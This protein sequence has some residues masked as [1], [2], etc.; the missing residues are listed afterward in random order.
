MSPL[1]RSPRFQQLVRETVAASSMRGLKVLEASVVSVLEHVV[2]DRAQRLDLPA[3]TVLEHIRVEFLTDLIASAAPGAHAVRPL[4]DASTAKVPA[5]L[6]GQFL[7]GIG[8]VAKYAGSNGDGQMVDHA[9]DLISEFGFALREGQTAGGI[10]LPGGWL[11]EAAQML[12]E[13]ADRVG[14]GT[15][16]GCPCG[17][18]H[19]QAETDRHVPPVMRADAQAP[20][21]SSGPRHSQPPGRAPA[22]PVSPGESELRVLHRASDMRRAAMQGVDSPPWPHGSSLLRPR[23]APTSPSRGSPSRPAADAHDAHD[24][25]S[26]RL[27]DLPNHR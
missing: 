17:V 6:A 1:T 19:G 25:A 7:A 23:S 22:S 16:T 5:G 18:E 9:G 4:R 2:Q 24:D 26:G 11:R 3:P 8:Q 21:G 14:A 12:E 13:T 20:S 10:T 15:W 27:D